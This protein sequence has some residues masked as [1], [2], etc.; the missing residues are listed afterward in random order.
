M[1]IGIFITSGIGNAIMM[2][3]LLKKLKK[4]GNN[5][6]FA[7]V[8]SPFIDAPWLKTIPFPVDE[9]IDLN[10]KSLCRFVSNHGKTFDII[11]LDISNSSLKNILFSICISRK[12]ISYRK[13]QIPFL[14]YKNIS[15]NENIHVGLLNLLLINEFDNL[16]SY[17][18]EDFELD[19]NSTLIPKIDLK[20][21]SQT[22]CV[23]MSAGNNKTPYKSWPIEK[24]VTLLNLISQNFNSI[25]IVLIGD[26]SEIKG[27]EILEN[28]LKFKID[29]YVGKTSLQDVTK[30]IQDST[31]YLGLDSG[32]MHLAVALNKP[33]ISIFGAS[34]PI[35]YGYQQFDSSKHKIIRLNKNCSPCLAVT[36]RNTTRVDSPKNCPDNNCMKEIEP[37]L[38]FNAFLNFYSHI[39]TE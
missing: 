14:P 3:P 20:S 16:R 26:K 25:K 21:K 19:Y 38:V 10:K 9:V 6:I 11:Y 33:T 34:N 24:W 2:I 27:S 29:N 18:L 31:L 13:K 32:L 15:S 23:Q 17:K 35:N 28:S 30:I 8:K 7:I 39:I 5:K 4:N 37:D 12:T 22:V 1:K 36:S